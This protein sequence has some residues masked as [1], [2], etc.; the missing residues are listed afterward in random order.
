[1]PFVKLD[2]GILDS[3][4]W[5]ERDQREV[6]LTALLMAE[7][8]EV[9]DPMPQLEVR[10]LETTGWEVPAGWYGMVHAAGVGIIRRAGIDEEPGLR[11]LELLGSPEVLS[12]SQD[13][14]GRRLVRVD[15][16]YIALNFFKYRDRDYSGAT[17]AKRYRERKKNAVTP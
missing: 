4:L 3:T 9:K 14:D 2:T 5:L 7:P 15:G 8:F 11:A 10:S 6:F 13:F 1:M 17:R 16:G 12:R